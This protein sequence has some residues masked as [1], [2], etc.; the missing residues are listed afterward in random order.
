MV[1]AEP[2]SGRVIAGIARQ[3]LWATTDGGQSWSALGQTGDPIL[4]RPTVLTYDPAHAGTFWES[5]IYGWE[6][7]FSNGVFVTTNDGSSFQGYMALSTI[8]SHQDSISIDFSDPARSTMLSGGHEQKQKLFLSKDAGKNWQDIGMALPAD[9][10]FCTATLVLDKET[11]LVGCAASWSGAASG[12]ILRSTNAGASFVEIKRKGVA[13]QPLWA[14]DGA[15]YWSAEGGGMLK[16]TDL[17]ATWSEL[18]DGSKTGAVPPIEMPDGRIASIG[19]DHVVLSK[20]GG[21]TW[22]PIGE[23]V[24]YKAGLAYSGATK[25]FFI[26]H[27]D[28]GN[29]V[30]SDA[31][32]SAGFDYTKE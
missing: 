20:D 17:G 12:A 32:M 11:Y 3:G 18:G 5:G 2:C 1:S 23:P 13:G 4:N 21:A 28:C 29:A 8:Q 22:T 27:N 31:V 15:I 10:G 9:V 19:S 14:S 26:W 30:L 16:S 24:P 25:T 6:N 7:P